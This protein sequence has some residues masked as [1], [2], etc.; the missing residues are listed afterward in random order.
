MNCAKYFSWRLFASSAQIKL[1]R[2]ISEPNKLN[3]LCRSLSTY[4]KYHIKRDLSTSNRFRKQINVSWPL[5]RLL[6]YIIS[7]NYRGYLAVSECVRGVHQERC[8]SSPSHFIALG[9][10]HRVRGMCNGKCRPGSLH[11]VQFEVGAIHPLYLYS[12]MSDMSLP[13]SS[14]GR[15]ASAITSQE[16]W[17][18]FDGG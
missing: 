1:L 6:A 16:S 18:G 13:T 5:H 8:S 7:Y 3:T 2:P 15:W 11:A 14:C 10:C 12:A 4:R 9:S 17:T